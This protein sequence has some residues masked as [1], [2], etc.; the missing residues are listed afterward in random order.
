M[1]KNAGNTTTL[2]H[3]LELLGGAGLVESAVGA[4]LV[5]QT[6]GGPVE[7]F[8]WRERNDEVDYVLRRGESV[9]AVEVK[10]GRARERMPGLDAFLRRF[11]GAKPLV[12]G[13][14]GIPLEDFLSTPPDR[15]VR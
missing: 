13:P 1:S 8:Y 12:V 10:S 15:W 3:Y 2:A 11:P 6:A 14:D 9:A 5:N 7:V 4:H